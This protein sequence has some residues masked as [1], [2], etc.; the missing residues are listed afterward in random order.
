MDRAFR[1]GK[2]HYNGGWGN[3]NFDKPPVSYEATK[4]YFFSFF[5]LGRSSRVGFRARLM[6][7]GEQNS[8]R[9]IL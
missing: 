6:M 1:T 8:L 9:G 3:S 7:L 2:T 5:F 4:I